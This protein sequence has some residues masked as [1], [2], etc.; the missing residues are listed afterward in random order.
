MPSE[1]YGTLYN[2]HD[3]NTVITMVKD[4]YAKKPEPANPPTTTGRVAAPFTLIKAPNGRSKR[5]HFQDDES[6]SDRIDKLTETLYRMDMEHGKP[7]KK[8]YK[9]YITNPRCR[10]GRSRFRP[11]GG[12]SSS[13]CGEGWPRS[14]SRFRGRRGDS[15]IEEDSREGNLTKAPLPRDPAYPAKLKTKTRINAIIAIRGDTSQLIALRETRLSP[16][17][18]LRGRNLKTI[19][20]PMEVQKNPSWLWPQ[21]CPKPMKKPSPLCNSP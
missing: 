20:T 17:S 6:L 8:L 4:I 7:S 11:R 21:P 1:I 2:Q 12:H 5:V 13:D 16:R 14:K 10:G 15:P 3:L 9:P 19:P 18:L